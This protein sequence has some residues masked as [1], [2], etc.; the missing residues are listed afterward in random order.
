MRGAGILQGERLE[1]NEAEE[2]M[3][4]AGR[5][6][7]KSART[8]YSLPSGPMEASGLKVISLAVETSR[9]GEISWRKVCRSGA[10]RNEKLHRIIHQTCETH[11]LLGVTDVNGNS[12]GAEGLEVR[13][14][15]IV[16]PPNG[17]VLS[18]LEGARGSGG[19]DLQYE[20][21]MSIRGKID[22]KW[23]KY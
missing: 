17:G 7:K 12:G 2:N 5:R 23:D 19:G 3:S 9:E 16:V 11:L 22:K 15:A 10:T 20:K 21:V 13:G 18:S 14:L 4:G 1:A 8:H 6:H